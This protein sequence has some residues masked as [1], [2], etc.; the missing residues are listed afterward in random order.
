MKLLR[1][2]RMRELLRRAI[3]K[4]RGKNPPSDGYLVSLI[5]ETLPNGWHYQ[6][7]WV[8]DSRFYKK[9]RV[10]VYAFAP[11]LRWHARSAT[12]YLEAA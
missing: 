5:Y 11:P 10:V 7:D 4:T 9:P 3:R 2:K 1:S 6:V 8:T 12:H